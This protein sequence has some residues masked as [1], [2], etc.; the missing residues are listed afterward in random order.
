MSRSASSSGPSI[1]SL[2]VSEEGEAR[3]EDNKKDKDEGT[4]TSRED[5]DGP[6]EDAERDNNVSDGD[7]DVDRG[8]IQGSGGYKADKWES[9]GSDG[10][11]NA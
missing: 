2:G 7:K 9:C 6:D 11:K 4:T 3:D 5:I 8:A 10:D 1:S